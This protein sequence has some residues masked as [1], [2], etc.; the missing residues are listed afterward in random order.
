MLPLTPDDRVRV[1]E[2]VVFRTIDGEAVLLHVDRGVYFGLDPIGTRVWEALVEHGCARPI[3]AP[4]LEEYDV[5]SDA[6]ESDI[7][8]LLNQLSANDLIRVTRERR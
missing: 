6:L 7:V 3:L 8:A 2:Q 5:E 1:N 4:L